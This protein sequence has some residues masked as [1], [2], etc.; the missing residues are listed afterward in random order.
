MDNKNF[1]GEITREIHWRSD[2][3]KMFGKEFEQKRKVAWLGDPNTTYTY[4]RIR[5][6]A[7]GWTKRV[8]TIKEK[9]KS[10]YEYE[11]NSCLVNLYR[12]GSDH[13]SYHS[14]NEKELGIN[15]AIF[16]LSF[17]ETRDFYLKH[18]KTGELIRL[19]L[20]NGDLLVMLGQ[21][22]D[23]WKHSLPKRSRVDKPRLNLTFRSINSL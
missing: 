15:P 10:D 21:T 19:A 20:S 17:G 13:M 4:S 11:F 2:K 9:I 14:D 1:I 23:F 12:D 5:M 6:V 7:S 18:N 16:S 22:Q 8:L 3:I